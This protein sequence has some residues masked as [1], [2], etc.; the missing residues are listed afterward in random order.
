MNHRETADSR[1][2]LNGLSVLVVEDEAIVSLLVEGMLIDLGCEDVWYASSVG[3]A[4][5]SVAERAPDLAVLDV[6]LGGEHAYPIARRLAEAGVPF[7][8]ATGY[9]AAGILEDWAGRPVLQKP[10]QCDMLAAALASALAARS[11]EK[12]S[13]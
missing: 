7:V 13:R 12:V 10:F 9:G 3:E 1:A 2:D 4:L 6:N 11:P 5:E 8:F